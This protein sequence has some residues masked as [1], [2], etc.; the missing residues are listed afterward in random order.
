MAGGSEEWR[1]GEKTAVGPVRREGDE[2]GDGA[3]GRRLPRVGNSAG[4]AALAW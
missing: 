4:R 2:A 3:V 1:E